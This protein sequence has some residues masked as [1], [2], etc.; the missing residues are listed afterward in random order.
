[1]TTHLRWSRLLHVSPLALALP[2]VDATSV[3]AQQATSSTLPAVTIEGGSPRAVRAAPKQRAA[4]SAAPARRAA[5]TPPPAVEAAPRETARGPVQGIVAKRTGT[6]SKTDSSILETPQSISV[7]T[8]EQIQ[9]QGARSVAEAL[10]YEP[11]VVAETRVG[12]RF[13]NVFIRGFGGFGANANYLHFWDGLRL[14]RGVSYA[15][16]SVDPFLLERVEILRGPA[17]VLY[18]QNN[19]GGMVNLISK[20]PTATPQGEVFT[21]FGNNNRVEGG[22]DVS[23]PLTKDG[24]LQYRL[25]GLGRK[26]DTDVNY[27]TTERQ[28]IAPTITWTPNSDTKLTVRGSYDRDPSSYQPNWLPA[29][30]TL[31]RNPNG[32]IPRDFFA[33]HPNFNEYSRTQTSVG[34]EFEHKFNDTWAVRQNLRYLEVESTFK[35]LSVTGFGTGASCGAGATTN[36]C[37]ARSSTYFLENLKSF[38]VDNQ[39]EAKFAT[40]WLNHTVLMGVD[41][42]STSATATSGNIAATGNIAPNSAANLP[43]NVNYLNPSYG[44]IVAPTLTTLT[45]QKREQTGVYVQDQMRLGK[46]A[47]TVGVRQDWANASSDTQTMATGV[48]TNRAKPVDSAATWRAGATYLFDNGFAPY[49]SY[50]TSFEPVIGTDYT[51]SAFVPTTGKQY[52]FGVKYQPT[53]LNGFFMLSYFDIVQNNVL[54]VDTAR[55]FAANPLCTQSGPNCQIQLGQVHSKGIELSAK[56]TLSPGFDVI[57][58]YSHTNISITENSQAALIGKVPVGAPGN[59]ASLWM[60]YTFQNGPLTGFGFGGGVRYVGSSFGDSA[61]TAAMVVPSYVLG[62]LAVHYDL[63]GASPQLKGWKLAVNMTNIT[64]KTYVSACASANQCFYGNGRTTLGTIRYQW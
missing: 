26:S 36:L 9:Q 17:S 28:L 56:A 7:V 24:D 50:S 40:G 45:V 23:G 64:D 51:G 18:G 16:P 4:R 46:L 3:L 42:Q 11:G 6:G 1:M 48:Y 62:D 59:T 27:T 8:R 30:G 29:L 60:D 31:Q 61:N 19:L 55:L 12:D 43:P 44:N 39:G 34:Y 33:G 21:R 15:M 41:Y 57:G 37:L 2:F 25:I 49:A 53:G 13:D 22:F 63:A 47:V 20:N 10:R 32:Q 14:P 54:A 5:V 38:T 35:A 58:A 52:E